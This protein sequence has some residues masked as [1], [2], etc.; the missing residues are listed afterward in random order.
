MIMPWQ[1]CR[2]K[3][4][5]IGDDGEV[6]IRLVNLPQLGGDVTTHFERDFF[7]AESQ[8]K[9]MLAIALTAVTTGL[10]AN[11][12]LQSTTENSRI[13]DIAVVRP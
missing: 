4:A 6:T 2:V 13:M 5:S 7:A 1:N 12:Q 11:V 8:R 10:H 3:T 9:E